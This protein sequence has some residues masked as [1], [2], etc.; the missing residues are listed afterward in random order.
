V[1]RERLNREIQLARQIQ[2]TFLPTHLPEIPGWELAIHWQTAREVGGDFYDV[3]K[4]SEDR[5]GLVVADVS[6]KGMPAALYMTVARTLIRAFVHSVSS[7][8]RVLERVNRLLVVESQDGLFVTAFYAILNTKTGI[9]TYAN[10]GHNLPLIIHAKDR[11]V[12]KLQRGGMALG[13]RSANK[14]EDQSIEITKGDSLLLYTDG[15]TESFTA[16]GNAFGEERL[17]AALQS[18]SSNRVEELKN[19]LRTVMSEYLGGE[20]L[21]DDLTLFFLHRFLEENPQSPT[22]AAE[23]DRSAIN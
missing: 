22:H 14:L 3:F 16:E 20:P 23:N 4:L 2:R 12:E 5:I 7:P 15:V 19:H 11:I 1:Q 17:I 6:D 8:A 21:S 13:V 18:A 9:L 10:A